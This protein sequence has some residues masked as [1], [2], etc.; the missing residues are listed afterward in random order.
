[1]ER[2]DVLLY[3]VVHERGGGGALIENLRELH[4]ISRS[5]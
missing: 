2:A 1:V 5:C 3:D 4:R